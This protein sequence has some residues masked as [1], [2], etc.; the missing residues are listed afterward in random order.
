M[1]AERWRY[2]IPLR[3]RLLLR[4]SQVDRELPA[5]RAVRVSPNAVLRIE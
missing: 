3:L 1:R 2:V 5:R 4:R